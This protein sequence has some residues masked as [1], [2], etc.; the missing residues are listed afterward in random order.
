[1]AILETWQALLLGIGIGGLGG[2]A[3]SIIGWL[4]GDEPFSTRKNIRS[5]ITAVFA[6]VG[7]AYGASVAF[8]EATSNEALIGVFV[9]TFLSAAGI[10]GLV[11]STSKIVS[12][13]EGEP[14]SGA[15]VVTPTA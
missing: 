5:I 1:M 7:V 2:F 9:L 10:Q 14:A 15:P 8:T 11:H 6:G 12:K 13:P 3:N 4:S